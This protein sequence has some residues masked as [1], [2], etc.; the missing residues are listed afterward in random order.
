MAKKLYALV[1]TSTET[2]IRTE[3]LDRD[4]E[5][6]DLPQKGW[7]WAKVKRQPPTFDPETEILVE[8]G[9]NVKNNGRVE[10]TYRVDP[11]PAPVPTLDERLASIEAR[12]DALEGQ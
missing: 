6:Q 8:T 2:V 3:Q 5:T 9:L 7:R 4:E 11:K 10:M 1:A 12:L